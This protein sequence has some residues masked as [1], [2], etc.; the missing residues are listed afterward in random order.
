[1]R[2]L[3]HFLPALVCFLL[4][5]GVAR[6]VC[7][8]GD[9]YLKA[10][11]VDV[12][13]SEEIRSEAAR[14]DFDP[15]RLYEFVRNEFEYQA[16]YGL[17]RGPEGALRARKGNEYD[18]AALLVS[19]LRVSEDTDENCD[20]DAGEDLDDDGQFDG[21]TRARFARGRIQVPLEQAR[22]WTRT[23]SGAAAA[24]FWDLTEPFAWGDQPSLGLGASSDATHVEKLHLWVEA[25][26]PMARYR[27]SGSSEEGRA[28]VPLD[29][30]FKLRDLQEGVPLP[31]GAGQAIEFDYE[32]YYA[33]VKQQLPLEIFQRQVRAYLADH[34]SGKSLA[35]VPI[36]GPIRHVAPGVIPNALPYA[37]DESAFPVQRAASLI[38]LHTD[39]AS[40][41]LSPEPEAGAEG[42]VDYRWQWGVRAC[43]G[44][45][46]SGLQAVA[47]WTADVGGKRVVL[48]YPPEDSGWLASHPEGYTDCFDQPP[49]QPT[50][51]VDGDPF[52]LGEPQDLCDPQDIRLEVP[53]PLPMGG[54]VENLGFG[55]RDTAIVGGTYVLALDTGSGSPAFTEKVSSDLVAAHQTYRLEIDENNADYAYIETDGT[56]GKS[57]NESYLLADFVAQDRLVGGL[58]HL[59]GVHYFEAVRRDTAQ[60]HDLHHELRLH[61]PWFGL[62]KSAPVVLTFLDAP[63]MVRPRHLM[64]DIRGVVDEFVDP[65]T[66]DRLTPFLDSAILSGHLV[67][68]REHAVWEELADA[69]AIS[70]VKA[71]QVQSEQGEPTLSITDSTNPQNVGNCNELEFSVNGRVVSLEHGE[72]VAGI[73]GGGGVYDTLVCSGIDADTYCKL[74][75]DW[76]QSTAMRQSLILCEIVIEYN[77]EKG[78]LYPPYG[79]QYDWDLYPNWVYWRA[80]KWDIEECGPDTSPS[81]WEPELLRIPAKSH[82]NYQGWEGYGYYER[83]EEAGIPVQR[84]G[85][86]LDGLLEIHGGYWLSQMVGD[87]L[88]G[89]DDREY[90][91]LDSYSVDLDAELSPWRNLRLFY[92]VT[93]AD[94]VSV[95]TGG[96]IHHEVD[97]EAPGRGGMGLRMRRSYSSRLDY[98]GPLGY[99]WVHTFDQHLQRDDMGTPGDLD[100][101]QVV[102]VDEGATETPFTYDPGSGTYSGPGWSHE[103]LSSGGATG[104]YTLVTK[105]GITYRFHADNETGKASLASIEDRNGN[106]IECKYDDAVNHP[107]RLTRVIDTA[108][109]E[110][111]FIY[112]DPPRDPDRLD[113]VTDW[114]NRRWDYEVDSNGDLREYWNPVE[115]ARGAEGRPVE[116]DYYSGLPTESLNHNI[117]KITQPA[118]RD[119][120]PGGDVTMEFV[121]YANDAVHSH[122]NA[123]GEKTT[124]SYNFFRRRTSV[125]HPD[126]SQEHYVY[127]SAA[128]VTR[129]ESPEGVVRE[130]DYEEGTHNRLSEWDGLGHETAATYVEAGYPD[131]G[132]ITSRTDRM[133]VS[134]SWE[135]ENPFSLPTKHTDRR[136]KVREWEYDATGNLTHEYAEVNG[137]PRVLLREHEYDSWGNRTA[138]IVYP[139]EDGKNPRVTR[140]DYA[141]NGVDLLRTVDAMGHETRF[142]LDELGRPI[143]T[144]T[145]RSVPGEIHPEVIRTEAV[146]DELGRAIQAIDVAGT[147]AGAEY[148]ENGKLTARFSYAPPADLAGDPLAVD[149]AACFALEGCRVELRN[150]Y[151]E[152]D[153]LISQTNARGEMTTVGYDSRGRP[154]RATSPLGH[155][156]SLEYDADGNLVRTVDPTGAAATTEH[157]A[158]GRVVRQVDALGR[159]TTTTYDKEG[160]VL[161]VTGPGP[162]LLSE[163]VQYDANGN[164]EIVADGEDVRTKFVY[165]E[166][167]RRIA[168]AAAFGEGTTLEA[169]TNFVYDLEGRLLEKH[170]TRAD[171][172]DE[173]VTRLHYDVLGR[174][175]R[176]EDPLARAAYF[177]YDELG[178]RVE[179]LSAAGDRMRFEYDARGLLTR[180]YSVDASSHLAVDDRFGY[181]GFGRQ[182]L[183][184]NIGSTREFEYDD[185]D[186]MVAVTDSS[187]QFGTVR[188]VYDA[189][190]RM[191]QLSYPDGSTVHYEYNPRGELTGI[192]DP[193]MMALNPAAGTWQLEY[194]GLGRPIRQTDPFGVER[195][196]D[197]TPEGF[198]DTVEIGLGGSPMET[199]TYSGYDLVGNPERIESSGEGVTEIRYD[200]RHRVSRVAYP[201]GD[202]DTCG[203]DCEEFEYDLVGNRIN[204]IANGVER[205]YVIDAADQ[206]TRITD[207]GDVD[208][209]TFSYDASGR[210]KTRTVVGTSETSSYDYDSLGRLRAGSGPGFGLYLVYAA[211]GDRLH[212]FSGNGAAFFGEWMEVRGGEKLRLVHGP[213]VDNVIAEVAEAGAVRTLA[214]DGSA[215]VT[216]VGID[217]ADEGSAR[218]YEAFGATRSGSSVVD[219]G[220]AGRPTEGASG[221]IYMR[222]RHYDPA[223]GRFLQSDPLG[224]E[225]DQLYAYAAGNPYVYGDPTGLLPWSL[226]DYG[227]DDFFRAGLDS[228]NPFDFSL[229]P[230]L[231]LA[232][233][234]Q[235]E[236][237]L[238]GGAGLPLPGNEDIWGELGFGAAITGTLQ[239]LSESPNP[240][241]SAIGDYGAISATVLGVGVPV[242]R[243]TAGRTLSRSVATRGA[244]Q[245]RALILR[246]YETL[247]PNG[248]RLGGFTTTERLQKGTLIDR[249]GSNT[250]RFV[251]PAGTPFSKR[252]LMP[253]TALERFQTFEVLQPLSVE[254]SIA[255]PAFGGGLG[256]QYRLPDTVQELIDARILGVK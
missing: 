114:T 70:T 111:T 230:R 94:P 109:R 17:M 195:T 2:A 247:A 239:Y 166:L 256:V 97:L 226:Q 183:A 81:T 78:C 165:D 185:L 58:L 73:N 218:R 253:E 126:G 254:G 88:R 127:D 196:V 68:A 113:Y 65:A 18:L 42:D 203:S 30:S 21:G 167:G 136:E 160:R 55:T 217:G 219:R 246:N 115:F 146:Y 227:V 48:S 67:S 102:W 90:S 252:G 19:L 232:E 233:Q 80:L 89:S 59:A 209:E 155:Q 244:S 162:I 250:G 153:R 13:L 223:T 51:S 140:F 87:S 12:V 201:G 38:P 241:V 178:N 169:T 66:G 248:G 22:G 9:P 72:L 105:A 156:T 200:R 24:N 175:V 144:E 152:A 20:L 158:E 202:I 204:H 138:T 207:A 107:D 181:D 122:T 193:V 132:N 86:R 235:R 211:T 120:I 39:S 161:T 242:L 1:M 128:N 98:D 197:Y 103:E 49:T 112:D 215:N 173:R 8:P 62:V 15:V 237:A 124:F 64:I 56:P 251:S 79:D 179:S 147:I 131:R 171:G 32:S 224:V 191:M 61:F 77:G 14:F 7:D 34:F 110:L 43:N 149:S 168:T 50:I 123:L 236:Q 28:W 172:E 137:S 190:G 92:D 108:G 214:R 26:V 255:S 245:S 74:K 106:L 100:D 240:L 45:D 212:R 91:F 174:L 69:E 96:Y 234:I 41:G 238:G 139:S 121:Y 4:A 243:S 95:I 46:C 154:V 216:R 118:D 71:I 187:S 148:D 116:Y 194:D 163:V 10:E 177:T 6:A 85:I 186:R 180:R 228:T 249:F 31:I 182:L 221:L 130:Y 16:Y 231:T 75:W 192:R 133:G 5:P 99:G 145:T 57:A 164:P 222:A 189:D 36:T 142:T 60:V 176:S 208:L 93:A 63:F 33:S 198:V 129:H 229:M 119:D 213:G 27:G 25:E 11:I 141:P 83:G 29:P 101:D 35:D 82:V 104:P 205:R 220:F 47:F 53:F 117:Q 225:A 44:A 157:D 40:G 23:G 188:Q 151:D 206:L 150:G 159:E 76:A 135:Y 199:Y 210:R 170:E 143:A 125:T 184:Q 52:S 37:I 54:D 134:E 84:F 3:S